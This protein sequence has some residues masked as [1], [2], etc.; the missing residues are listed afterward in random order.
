MVTLAPR[1]YSSMVGTCFCLADPL[2]IRAIQ[3]TDRCLPSAPLHGAVHKTPSRC[4]CC[5]G[6]T[7]PFWGTSGPFN[8]PSQ[9]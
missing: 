3:S 5:Y 6:R 1:R 2:T 4:R 8:E 9:T 7:P